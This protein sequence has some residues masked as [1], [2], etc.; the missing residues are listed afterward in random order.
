MVYVVTNTFVGSGCPKFLQEIGQQV[1]SIRHYAF[2]DN[3][4]LN[5]YLKGLEERVKK[6]AAAKKSAVRFSHTATEDGG[7]VVI[8]KEGMGY[9]DFIRFSYII[10]KGHLFPSLDN[11]EIRHI[12]YIKEGGA[13]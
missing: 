13:L 5:R 3:D 4:K 12:D 7:T 8:S 1:L 2:D 6:L 10:V 11:L 9:T